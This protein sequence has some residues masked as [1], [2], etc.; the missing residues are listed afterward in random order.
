M[1]TYLPF[2]LYQSY[3]KVL[4]HGSLGSLHNQSSAVWGPVQGQVLVPVQGRSVQQRVCAQRTLPT[5]T[6]I[7]HIHIAGSVVT[8]S[9][10]L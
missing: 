10:S 6:H 1:L 7:D 4:I 9:A 8:L 5:D 3:P 2:S